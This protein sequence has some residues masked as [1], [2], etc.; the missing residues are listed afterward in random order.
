VINAEPPITRVDHVVDFVRTTLPPLNIACRDERMPFS[1]WLAL[2]AP[3]VNGAAAYARTGSPSDRLRLLQ[4]LGLILTSAEYHSQVRGARPG[5]IVSELPGLER[6]LRICAG[7]GRVPTL[8]AE[9]YW[10]INDAAPAL[11]FTADSY[12]QFFISAVRTQKWLRSVVNDQLRA[13]LDGRWD[14]ATAEAA[15]VLRAA[16][17]T[18]REARGQYLDFRKGPDGAALMTPR[19]F[20]DM[21]SWLV[22]TVIADRP[23]DGPNAA[24]IGDMIAT[25]FLLGTAND[26]YVD[27]VREIS[28]YLSPAGRLMVDRDMARQPLSLALAETAGFSPLDLER[29][30]VDEVAARIGDAP[31]GMLWTLQAFKEL[32]DEYVGASGT[33]IGLVH[34]YLERF[35]EQLDTEQMSRMPVNPTEG[36]GGHPH[37][38]TRRLHD[39]RRTAPHIRTVLMGLKRALT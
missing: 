33:H 35:A 14:L 31:R 30:T 9:L 8:T 20:N 18:M 13:I 39:M 3:T 4:A 5:R 10:E 29:A 15:R 24:Y 32:V 11:S 21:R 1:R 19:Q 12:E 36:T 7:D 2:I 17:S 28:A 6:T 37:A 25:D 38:H 22:S 26:E 16:A 34:V 23:L 27:Y